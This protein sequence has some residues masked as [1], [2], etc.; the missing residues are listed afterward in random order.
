M[1]DFLFFD[2]EAQQHLRTGVEKLYKAVSQ[3]MG[4]HGKLA[5]IERMGQPPHLTKDGA[6]VAKNVKLSNPIESLG[7][8]LIKQASE[9]TAQTVGDGSTTATVLTRELYNKSIQALQTGILSSNEMSQL[10]KSRV[11]ILVEYLKENAHNISTNEEIKQI[12]AVSANG[13]TKIGDLIAQAISEVGSA[14]LVTVQKSKTTQTNLQLVKGVRIERGYISHY[15]ANGEERNKCTL[16]EPFVLILNCKL[17]SL[18]QL[19][20]VLEKVA[21]S[22][23]SILVIANDFEDEV[24]QAMIT[25][26]TRGALKICAIKSPFYGENRSQILQD[27]ADSLNSKVLNEIDEK[28]IKNLNLNDLGTCKSAIV[29]NNE[30]LLVECGKKSV[31]QSKE[32]AVNDNIK[33]IDILLQNKDLSKEEEAFL[34]QRLI[35]LKGVVA[36]LSIGA[37]TESELLETFDRVDDALHATKAA[38]D[39]GFLPGGGLSLVR[40]GQFLTNISCNDLKEKTINKIVGDACFSPMKQILKNADLSTDYIIEKVKEQSDFNLGYNITSG[41]YC[42]LI[43]AGVIDPLQVSITALRNAASAASS[44]INIGCVILDNPQ[45]YQQDVQMVQ[46][47]E[48]ME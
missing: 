12:A 42:D 2:I 4:P 7:A 26:V 31:K 21:A 47:A 14:K 9:Q 32:L 33:Q 43:K 29:S 46:L 19:I 3:T 34:K 37:Y 27:L 24:I 11:E 25:N 30:T 39:G 20:P 1:S 38:M 17:N 23:K 16:D 10:L 13:D 44:L 22:E 36:V 18:S 40:A 28:Q 15:F 41:E 5:L 45:E 6:T 8:S 35:I 48:N